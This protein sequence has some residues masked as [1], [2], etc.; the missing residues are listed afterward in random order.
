VQPGGPGEKAGI[1]PGDVVRS[2]NGTPVNQSSDL[3]P[4]VGAMAP[5]TRVRLGVM[6]EGRE[7]EVTVTLS[8]LDDGIAAQGAPG[9]DSETR[10]GRGPAATANALG[11]VGQELDANQRRQLGLDAGQGVGIARVQG[12]AAREAGIRPGDVVLQVGRAEV[13][14]AAAL[15]RELRNVKAGETVMLLLRR[16]NATQFVAVTPRVDGLEQ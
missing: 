13:G 8:E 10:P 9:R 1:V 3:P 7:R 12:L 2:V 5:G 4:I 14:S 11:L 15:D 6:R 16:G